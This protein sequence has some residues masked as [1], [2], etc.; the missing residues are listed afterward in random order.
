MAGVF[1]VF[2]FVY[3]YADGWIRKLPRRAAKVINWVGFAVAAIGGIAWYFSNYDVFM[4][5]TLGGI[6][7]YFL[8]Y[9]YD[10]K[11]EKEDSKTV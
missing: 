11:E 3:K 2:M 6:I 7:T 10:K 8:F 9:G 4:F 5:V 1:I